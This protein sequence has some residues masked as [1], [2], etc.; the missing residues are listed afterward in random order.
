MGVSQLG[1][2]NYDP[3]TARSGSGWTFPEVG[4]FNG[5]YELTA[6]LED[7]TTDPG[8]PTDPTDPTTPTF[9]PIFGSLDGDTIEVAGSGQLIFAG[10]MNDLVDASTGEGNNRIYAQSGDDTL[11]LGSSDRVLAGAGGD[12]IFATS[13]GDNILTGGEGADQFWIATASL[14]ESAN[15]IT[16]FMSGE[17]VFAF[18]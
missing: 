1:N 13:G 12:A 7:G 9:E 5:F 4:V 6:T 3:F 18:A 10:D 11:V 16:D 15:I 14:P 8:D 2:R 17:S